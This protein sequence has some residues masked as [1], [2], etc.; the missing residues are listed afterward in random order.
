M[1][2]LRGRIEREST[3][4]SVGMGKSF[5]GQVKTWLRK[6]PRNLQE[7]F[8]LRLLAIADMRPELAI[9]CDQIVA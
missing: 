7:R 2:R 5:R 8:H 1:I 3:E 6:S 4:K 9:T